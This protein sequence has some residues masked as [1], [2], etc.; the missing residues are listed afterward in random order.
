MI[1]FPIHDWN[2][3]LVKN[4]SRCKHIDKNILKTYLLYM[5]KIF[6]IYL[7]STLI[8]TISMFNF[9]I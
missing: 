6:K 9:Y 3:S 4:K 7:F 8:F 5:Y 2:F 1:E